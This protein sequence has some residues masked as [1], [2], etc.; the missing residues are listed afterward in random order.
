MD[1]GR[2]A[3]LN[4][5]AGGVAA[6]AAAG[7]P[8]A[9]AAASSAATIVDGSDV[10]VLTPEYFDLLRQG[11]VQV[12]MWN[13]PGTLLDISLALE[14]LD[15]HGDRAIL[16]KSA[17]EI[18]AAIGAGRLAILFGFQDAAAFTEGAGNDCDH[19][20]LGPDFTYGLDS[21]YVDPA[22]QFEFPPEMTYKQ[23]P[24]RFVK[25]FENVSQLGNVTAELRKRNYTQE[26]V[27]KIL[28]GNWLRVYRAAWS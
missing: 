4:A 16:A 1:I 22:N 28:G 3:F 23:H 18:E 11:G 6:A 2:R 25:G 10:S 19:I 9:Q 5:A 13:G 21:F 14:F 20:G 8:N 27:D 7:R 12:M 15:K 26:N 24:V 17:S